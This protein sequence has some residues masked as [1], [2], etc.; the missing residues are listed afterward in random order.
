MAILLER[1]IFRKVIEFIERF[2]TEYEMTFVSFCRSK[3]VVVNMVTLQ[4][5]LPN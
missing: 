3:K 5:I 1:Y 4:I 2:G